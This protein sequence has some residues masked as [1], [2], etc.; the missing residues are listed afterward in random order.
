MQAAVY[1]GVGD[2]RIEDVEE[3]TPAAGQVKIQVAYNGLCG[4]DLHEVF[5]GQRAVPAEPHPLTAVRAPVILGH[6]IAG[7][8]VELGRGVS[9]LEAGMLV[10]VE[11]LVACGSCR[12]CRAGRVNLCDRLA[13]H[14]LST[15]GGGLAE[16][17]VVSRPMLHAAP[18]GL[19]ARHAAMAEPLAVAWHAVERSGAL[20][21]QTA[22][23]LGG[24]PIGIGIYLVLR[25]RDIEAVV[26]EPSRD[27]RRLIAALGAT[28]M[29]PGEG[30]VAAALRDTTGG[31]GV[32]V[33]FET[34]ATV[35]A[36]ETALGATTKQGTVMLLASP[37]QPLPP[38]LGAALAGELV[39]RTSY[40]YHGEFPAVLEALAAG[41]LPIDGWVETAPLSELH[42]A[43]TD[44]RAGHLAKVLIDPA[45][46][47]R[48]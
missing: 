26:V 18:P 5:D 48:L 38:V 33:C 3:P 42:Q 11:P 40:A 4:T 17:T 24:G 9:D 13:F 36:I 19:G 29:D 37:R 7:T 31:R 21:G 46:I 14:G 32:D 34:S 27:R 45:P 22:A 41:R 20:G 43:L 30:P 10:A 23:V 39:I 35:A 44:M 47:D 28:T 15:A 16:Y 1:H 2:V 6:E 8:V 25:A 12:W